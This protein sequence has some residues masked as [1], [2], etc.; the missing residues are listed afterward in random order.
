MT[1][2]L[3]TACRPT[4]AS[5]A[6]L[7]RRVGQVSRFWIEYPGSFTITKPVVSQ[8]GRRFHEQRRAEVWAVSAR[9]QHGRLSSPYHPLSGRRGGTPHVR[10]QARERHGPGGWQSGRY[11]RRG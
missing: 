1:A 10:H 8:G 7:S 9:Y 2:S 6:R 3:T 11:L 5:V 4:L